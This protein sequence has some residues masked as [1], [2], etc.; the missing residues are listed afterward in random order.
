MVWKPVNLRLILTI[1]NIIINTGA[2]I[3]NIKCRSHIC[4]HGNYRNIYSHIIVSVTLKEKSRFLAMCS[5]VSLYATL[6]TASMLT[7]PW[8]TLTSVI[9]PLV[10]PIEAKF[11]WGIKHLHIYITGGIIQICGCHNKPRLMSD[12]VLFRCT[13]RPDPCNILSKQ[14]LFS[15][16]LGSFSCAQVFS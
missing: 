16:S 14:F 2:N 8:A 15:E 11:V 1:T 4:S 12:N 9:C 7:T 5:S 6:V 10:S 13:S 3:S